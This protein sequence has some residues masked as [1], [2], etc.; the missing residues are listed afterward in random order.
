MIGTVNDIFKTHS[1]GRDLSDV[2][3]RA[4]TGF[5][6]L[7]NAI[8]NAGSTDPEKIRQALVNL[9]MSSDS[10]IVPYRGIK[11]GADGQNEKTRGILM[12]VQ[13][14]KYCTVYPFE[15]AACKLQYP[16]PTWAQK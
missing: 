2:P 9:D 6:A 1:G 4:F 10:L 8:N 7:A 12:Q 15:L 13:G 11:F 16:L 3:A 14:G 5:M